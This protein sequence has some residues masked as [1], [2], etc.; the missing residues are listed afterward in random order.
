MSRVLDTPI[1]KMSMLTFLTGTAIGAPVGLDPDETES[2]L[3]EHDDSDADSYD[4]SEDGRNKVRLRLREIL[5][6][7][8]KVAIF[9]ARHGKL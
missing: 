2:E 3:S 1:L 9:K 7:D 4:G 8:D 5:F 6:Y